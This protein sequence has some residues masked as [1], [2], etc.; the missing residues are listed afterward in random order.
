MKKV[1]PKIID[2]RYVVFFDHEMRQADP[3]LGE[4]ALGEPALGEPALG[5]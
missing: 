5:E 4:P 3:A 1:S 2:P